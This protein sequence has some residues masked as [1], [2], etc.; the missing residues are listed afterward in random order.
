MCRNVPPTRTCSAPVTAKPTRTR[1]FTTWPFVR[2]E[3]TLRFLTTA[4]VLVSQVRFAVAPTCSSIRT[5]K[6]RRFS[7]HNLKRFYVKYVA[8][9]FFLHIDV[10]GFILFI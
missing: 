5:G 1:A 4:A 2:L 8:F 6:L 7:E 9:K 10:Y 3:G